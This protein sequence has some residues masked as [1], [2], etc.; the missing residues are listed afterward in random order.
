MPSI[1]TDAQADQLARRVLTSRLGLRPKENVT[2]EAYPSSLPWAAGFVRQAR[3]LGARPLLHYEDEQSYWHA[4]DSGNAAIL[5][6][7]GEHEWAALE[8]SDVYVYFWGPEDQAR[9]RSLP[10]AT[11]EKL[12]AFNSRWYDLAA[13]SGVRGVRM[14]IARATEDNARLWG[15]SLP[16]WRAE[17][18]EASSREPRE[19]AADAS[20]IRSALAR[21]GA[22][23]VQH[24][25]GTDLTL[26]LAKREP[27]VWLGEVTAKSRRTRFGMMASVPDANV[28]VTVDE[29]RAEG[30][31]VANRP[32]L[33]LGPPLRGGRWAF[34]GGRLTRAR[35]AEGERSFRKS[36]AEAPAGKDRP[37]FVEIGLD[38]AIHASPTF[39]ESERGAVTIGVGGNSGLGGRTKCDFISY[40]TI[41]DAT[42]EL[43][44]RPLVRGGRIL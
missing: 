5:G 39:E 13:K 20:R 30:S 11:Q 43:D 6:T 22:L 37:A 25:N 29:T 44:G 2:I 14:G 4:V 27:Q 21:G 42:V 16:R 19:L 32:T 18:L 28:L 9:F 23:R 1:P 8:N 38:P 17:L 7:P 34:E 41:A 3:K 40:V 35:Y 10:E 15:V 26:T 33:V 31:L 36:Y 24:P 12:Y